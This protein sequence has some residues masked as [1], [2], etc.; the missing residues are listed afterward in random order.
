MRRK[1]QETKGPG[2]YNC[3]GMTALLASGVGWK[4]EDRV[5]VGCGMGSA[6]L[7]TS[8]DVVETIAP[9]EPGGDRVEVDE[10]RVGVSSTEVEEGVPIVGVDEVVNE[11]ESDVVIVVVVGVFWELELVM[12]GGV[13]IVR[14]VAVVDIVVVVVSVGELVVIDV[15]VNVRD[16]VAD[17]PVETLGVP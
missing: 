8:R 13:A 5:V 16:S 4:A 1:K 10:V 3:R 6:V 11:S 7:D 9:V 2:T 14:D 15:P 17:K 12:V